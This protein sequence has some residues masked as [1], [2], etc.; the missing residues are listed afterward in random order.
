MILGSFFLWM[1]L[2]MNA[3]VFVL[4]MYEIVCLLCTS[5]MVFLLMKIVI[6]LQ[7]HQ[8]LLRGIVKR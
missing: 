5:N 3:V 8:Q 4:L 7:F 2:Q 6:I 1:V